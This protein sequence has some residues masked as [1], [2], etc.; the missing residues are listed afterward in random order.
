MASVDFLLLI[1]ARSIKLLLGTGHFKRLLGTDQT[2]KVCYLARIF[3]S[4]ARC[5]ATYYPNSHVALY[6]D[7]I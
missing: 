3:V 1:R 5:R 6:Q 7:V 2:E 4:A